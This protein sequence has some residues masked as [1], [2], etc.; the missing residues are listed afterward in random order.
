[1]AADGVGG[2]DLEKKVKAATSLENWPA[3]NSALHELSAATND[4]G[5]YKEIMPLL[6]KRMAEPPRNWRT[7]YKSLVLLEHL[8]RYGSPRVVEEARAHSFAIRQLHDFH[9]RD[10]DTDKDHGSG[11]RQKANDIAKMLDDPQQLE[12]ARQ[13]AAAN[14]HKFVGVSSHGSVSGGGSHYGGGGGGGYDDRGFGGGSGAFG[15]NTGVPYD[16]QPVRKSTAAAASSPYADAA[17]EGDAGKKKKKKKSKS[18]EGGSDDEAPA[19]AAAAPA[20]DD[21][22]AEASGSAKK[23]KKKSKSVEEGDAAAGA[24]EGEEKKKKKKNK[25]GESAAPVALAA[26]P[27]ADDAFGDFATASFASAPAPASAAAIAPSSF[28]AQFGAD[29]PTPAPA[30]PRPAASA[31]GDLIDIFASTSLNS[32]AHGSSTGSASNWASSGPVDFLSSTP[33]AAAQQP[34][35]AATPDLFDM[36]QTKKGQQR[37]PTASASPQAIQV[38]EHN[39]ADAFSSFVA[40]HKP[41]A[42]SHPSASSAAAAKKPAAPASTDA[43]AS[44]LVDLGG[45]T[46]AKP[47][48][49][50]S[51]PA[52]FIGL[53]KGAGGSTIDPF[54]HIAGHQQQQQRM[55]MGR[56]PPM[57]GGGFGGMP[58]GG[59]QG[60]F[61]GMPGGGFGGMPGGGMGGFGGMQQQQQAGFGFPQQQQPGFGFPQQQQQQPGFGFQQKP[62]GHDVFF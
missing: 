16:E 21:P 38:N 52:P 55:P 59:M 41:A 20:A 27:A 13:T 42:S 34:K 30:A 43:W 2:T 61:G 56:G 6:W 1:V 50:G 15:A 45:M 39:N 10:E 31:G 4:Y 28:E 11:V 46:S 19:A 36:A 33:A 8:L 58:G 29:V 47:A 35:P 40:G 60:G 9:Y 53:A 32:S 22:Y 49:S 12:Q 17:D 3:T 54:S 14:L 25:A 44:S 57:A 24:T 5:A 51:A 37:A 7:I 23:K 62:A 48:P 18:K 26:P